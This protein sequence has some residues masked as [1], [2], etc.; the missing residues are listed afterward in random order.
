MRAGRLLEW[1]RGSLQGVAPR[2]PGVW[3]ELAYRIE[4]ALRALWTGTILPPGGLAVFYEHLHFGLAIA[5]AMQLE[6]QLLDE[7]DLD[8]ELES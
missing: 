4:R 1:L 8:R 3:G 6:A 7:G 2:D 5:E